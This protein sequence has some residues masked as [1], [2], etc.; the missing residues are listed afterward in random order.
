MDSINFCADNYNTICGSSASPFVEQWEA[1]NLTF[2]E[3]YTVTVKVEV[4]VEDAVQGLD[5]IDGD[6]LD[7]RGNVSAIPEIISDIF[8]AIE[9]QN[10]SECLNIDVAPVLKLV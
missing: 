10:V 4:L 5:L 2:C 3:M 8:D 9:E 6:L 1:C 7:I